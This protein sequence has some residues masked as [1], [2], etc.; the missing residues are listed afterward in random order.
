MA[1]A[2]GSQHT[3]AVTSSGRAMAVGNNDAGQCDV[4]TWREI[5][6]VAAGANHT[7][8]LRADGQVVATGDNEYG[9]SNVSNWTAIGRPA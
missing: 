9:Q 1:V 5:V 7:L 3:V 6:E 8:G 2:A 4:S